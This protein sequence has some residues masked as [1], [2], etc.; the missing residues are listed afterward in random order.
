MQ[1]RNIIN[2]TT[3]AVVAPLLGFY[4]SLIPFLVLAIVLIF[5][6]SRFGV[7]DYVVNGADVGNVNRA[8]RVW[9]NGVDVTGIDAYVE[10]TDGW[11]VTSDVDPS[12][13]HLTQ[14]Q[15]WNQVVP[16]ATDY[17]IKPVR[18]HFYGNVPASGDTIQLVVG[19]YGWS[20]DG[21]HQTESGNQTYGS[22]IL[23]AITQ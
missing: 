5:V 8:F 7:A 17:G 18:V 14:G 13:I 23:K 22:C 19:G 4:N 1:E 9:V 11:F 6:D 20:D 3:T 12:L 16:F 15:D 2:G 10:R 21:V